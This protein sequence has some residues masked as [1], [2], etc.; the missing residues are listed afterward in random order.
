[1]KTFKD[2]LTEKQYSKRLFLVRSTLWLSYG[3]D[4]GMTA[5]VPSANRFFT[6][7]K[8]DENYD[9]IVDAIYKDINQLEKKE[10]SKYYYFEVPYYT[11]SGAIWGS[12]RP[13]NKV[14]AIL[15]KEGVLVLTFFKTKSEADRWFKS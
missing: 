13:E 10:N 1:M 5:Q 14:Y 6:N 8:S 11:S 9:S 4:S 3:E 12:Q 7:K 2:Y 15:N